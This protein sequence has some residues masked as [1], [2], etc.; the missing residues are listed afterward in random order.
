MIVATVMS[1]VV[2]Q[3]TP[4]GCQPTDSL[5]SKPPVAASSS[6]TAE[7][8]LLRFA[9]TIANRGCAN[10][11]HQAGQPFLQGRWKIKRDALAQGLVGLVQAVLVR[12]RA[13]QLLSA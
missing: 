9:F 2:M 13:R 3:A 1:L 4:T 12:R 8:G 5:F 7:D 10:G 6:C 11:A